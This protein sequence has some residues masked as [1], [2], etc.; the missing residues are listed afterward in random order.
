MTPE[1]IKGILKR[2]TAQLD[3]N[4]CKYKDLVITP[5][6]YDNDTFITATVIEVYKKTIFSKPLETKVYCGLHLIDGLWNMEY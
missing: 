6:E 4:T 3:F 2:A 1:L 5:G